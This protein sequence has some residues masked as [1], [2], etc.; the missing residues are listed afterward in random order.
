MRSH[1]VSLILGL[2]FEDPNNLIRNSR[3]YS[4]G[5]MSMLSLLPHRLYNW[6]ICIQLSY[7]KVSYPRQIHNGAKA[8]TDKP[9]GFMLNCLFL[10]NHPVQAVQPLHS[11]GRDTMRMPTQI[12]QPLVVPC[13]C[14]SVLE[15][16]VLLWLECWIN[17]IRNDSTTYCV[18]PGQV[19]CE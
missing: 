4:H 15:G 17:V 8:S 5:Y 10:L 3:C 9:E 1:W 7:L 2:S 13:K 12:R 11:P 6:P 16:R 14:S 19:I 18:T